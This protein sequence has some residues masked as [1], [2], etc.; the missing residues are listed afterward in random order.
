MRSRKPRLHQALL[1]EL[2]GAGLQH[3]VGGQ[4][5][6]RAHPS[7]VARLEHGATGMRMVGVVGMAETSRNGGGRSCAGETVAGLAEQDQ[8]GGC[9]AEEEALA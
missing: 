8:H 5:Q 3:Q 9:D 4:R 1:G 7:V 6:V 2:P